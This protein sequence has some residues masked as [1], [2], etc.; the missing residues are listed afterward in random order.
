MISEDS[1]KKLR[2][3]FNLNIYE[4]KVWVALLSKGVATAGELS[5]MSDVPRSRSYDVLESLEKKGFIIMKLGRPIRYLAVAPAEIIKRVKKTLKERS[6]QEIK[7]VEN[8][9][10]TDVFSELN[11]LYKLGIEHI[12]PTSIAG[13]FKG[14][15]NI[16]D[17]IITLFNQANKEMCIATTSDGLGR[18]L[19]HMKNAF[20]KLNSNNIDIKIA[21]SLK[22]EKAKEIAKELSAY[23][24]VKDLDLDARF[25]IIDGKDIVFMVNHEKDVHES[26]ETGVWVNSSFF[27]NAMK[28]MF[29][30]SWNT[31]K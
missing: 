21:A 31:K 12:D 10:T 1:L 19:E 11:L 29:M 9:Q 24:T 13:S 5:D 23:A 3:A 20:K 6:D 27:A 7:S 4:V 26:A 22:T 18:K 16:Y 28:G 25:V 30:T 2:S 8:V 15:N 14:R 17:H